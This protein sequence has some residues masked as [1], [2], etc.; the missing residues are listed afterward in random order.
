MH[1]SQALTFFSRPGLLLTLCLS[2]TGC[3]QDTSLI[4]AVPVLLGGAAVAGLGYLVGEQADIE[5]PLR[6]GTP[7][8]VLGQV[9][10]LHFQLRLPQG[11]PL[12]QEVKISA[13]PPGIVEVLDPV[14]YTDETIAGLK[15]AVDQE[16]KRVERYQNVRIPRLKGIAVGQTQIRI[17]ALGTVRVQNVQVVVPDVSQTVGQNNQS[18]SPALSVTP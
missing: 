7:L 8:I 12:R 11:T 1:L 2:L 13:H 16:D 17:E 9:R 6:E 15:P 3:G 10:A 4:A 18:P 14:F 5:L